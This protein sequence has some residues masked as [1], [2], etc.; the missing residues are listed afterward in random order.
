MAAARP[1][2]PLH[3]FERRTARAAARLSRR[4]RRAQRAV[5]ALLT[6]EEDYVY[7]RPSLTNAKL[8]R[9]ELLAGAP[10]RQG[11]SGV[12]TRFYRLQEIRDRERALPAQAQRAY[13]QLVAD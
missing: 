4:R 8:R 7:A 3:E 10:H 2:G 9:L 6:R 13:Q 12:I 1:A 11:R 5:L